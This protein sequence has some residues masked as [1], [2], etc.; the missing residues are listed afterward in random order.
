MIRTVLGTVVGLAV[1]LLLALG[2]LRRGPDFVLWLQ[3][4]PRF[5]LE[6]WVNYLVL[7]LGGGFGAVCGALAGL[8][9]AVAAALRRR[10]TPPSSSPPAGERGASAP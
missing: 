10:P 6:P 5:A 9:G 3:G 8:A 7:V 2:L 4:P 1:G